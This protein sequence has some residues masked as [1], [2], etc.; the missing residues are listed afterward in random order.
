[1]QSL[2]EIRVRELR[3]NSKVWDVYARVCVLVYARVCVLARVCVYTDI[4]RDKVIMR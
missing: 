3:G 2:M 4:S 1:M